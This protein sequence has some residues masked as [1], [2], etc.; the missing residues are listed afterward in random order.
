LVHE[1]HELRQ[2]AITVGR[3]FSDTFAGIAPASGPGFVAAQLLGGLFA[4]AIIKTLY[5]DV[6]PAE[7]ADVVLPHDGTPETIRGHA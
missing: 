3:M 6:T 5:P 7:A 2:P 4:I 1:L